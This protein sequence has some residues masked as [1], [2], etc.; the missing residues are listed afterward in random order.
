MWRE[1]LTQYGAALDGEGRITKGDK[2]L[3]V[4]VV[5]KRGRLRFE[6]YPDG[7]LIGS[8][9]VTPQAVCDFVESFWFW[10]KRS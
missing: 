3:N 8:G 5:E 2:T 6:S 10:T 4:R 9:P 1:A 7:R